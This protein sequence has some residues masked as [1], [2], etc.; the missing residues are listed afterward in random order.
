MLK[1]WSDMRPEYRPRAACRV[2]T[3]VVAE[4][5]TGRGGVY[6]PPARAEI[7]TLTAMTGTAIAARRSRRFEVGF[8]PARVYC[9]ASP[10]SQGFPG[11]RELTLAL[12]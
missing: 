3:G 2:G 12:W 10:S 1:T 5:E 7:Y 9:A 8:N 4:S 11:D 6:G